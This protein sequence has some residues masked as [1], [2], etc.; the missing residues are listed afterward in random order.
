M[1]GR[2]LSALQHALQSTIR[3]LACC[4]DTGCGR[5]LESLRAQ[6]IVS[7]KWN[8]YA[9]RMLYVQVSAPG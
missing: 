3:L 2:L 9:L 4:L 8:Q 6:A 7:Y 5:A 1:R